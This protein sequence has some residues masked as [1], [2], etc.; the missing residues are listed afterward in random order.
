MLRTVVAVL[1]IPLLAVPISRAH[2]AQAKSS[3][4]K[5]SET[6]PSETKPADAPVNPP[7][8]PSLD[9]DFDD[10]L[11][12]STSAEAPLAVDPALDR[13]IA[14]RRTM[15]TVHQTLGLATAVTLAATVVVGQLNFDDRY[16]GFGATDRYRPWH[17]GLVIGSSSLFAGTGLLGLLAPTPFKKDFRWD[18]ITFHK[19]FMSIAT[20]GMLSQ[21]ALGR[22]TVLR[23]GKLSQVDLVRTH[24]AIGYVTLGAVAAGA[25]MIAF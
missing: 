12:P 7:Q 25:L 10:L 18:T 15:L 2:A 22:L 8:E 5:P 14:R 21:V 1:L 17:T 19:L 13:A 4:S 20:A 6:K 16:R 24:Q 11:A 3:K 23:E 9:T